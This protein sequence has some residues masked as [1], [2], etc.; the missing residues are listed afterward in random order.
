MDDPKQLVELV[1]QLNIPDE[2]SNEMSNRKFVSPAALYW[3]VKENPEAAFK[4]ILEG[5]GVAKGSAPSVMETMEAG[6]LR[7]LL[8]MCKACCEKGEPSSSTALAVLPQNQAQFLGLDLGP[9]LDAGKLKQL[10]EDFNKNYPSEQ[11]ESE[12]RPCKQLVQQVFTQRHQ[13]DLRFIPWKQVVSEVQADNAKLAQGTKEKS[14]LALLAEAS[15]QQDALEVDPSPSPYVVQRI[16]KLRGV[17]WALVGWCHLGS[18]NKLSQ[19]FLSLYAAPNLGVMGLRAPSLAEAEAADAELCR[20]LNLLMST[21]VSL[22]KAI[23][24][25]A[26]VR[27][28][29]HMWLQPRAISVGGKKGKGKGKGSHPYARVSKGDGK[30]GGKHE[31]ERR[32]KPASAMHSRR[33]SASAR[34]ASLCT[35]ANIVAARTMVGL[36]ARCSARDNSL[37]LAW[38]SRVRT[39]MRRLNPAVL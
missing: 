33:A 38:L 25:V 23:H 31:S 19:K 15:G 24:E 9:K 14:F 2:V 17:C 22:D 28:S 27:N 29:L 35:S 11:L 5:A 32:G 16:L 8:S 20:Q 39:K 1:K 4:S 36:S 30:G 3:S 18:A 10:W 7:R 12:S 37:P 6:Q 26:V 21:G 13:K 34:T